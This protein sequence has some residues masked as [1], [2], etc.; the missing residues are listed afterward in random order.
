MSATFTATVLRWLTGRLDTFADVIFGPSY[1]D[2]PFAGMASVM[3]VALALVFAVAAYSKITDPDQTAAEFEQLLVPAPA[4]T[5]RVIPLAEML[6]SSTLIL[7][8][9]VG[10]TLAATMLGAFT[11]LLVVTVRSGRTVS[12]G[13]L[14]A[15]ST[16]PISMA[17]VARNF[18]FLAM[19]IFALTV[20]ALTMPSLAS[21]LVLGSMVVLGAMVIQLIAL[22]HAVGRIWSVQLA[23]ETANAGSRTSRSM[24]GNR[25]G[26]T[27]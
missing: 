7:W 4:I 20:P 23:G 5:A 15:L 14:G 8:P 10:A 24:S 27:A 18:V 11:T 17:T 2:G 3:A 22:H 16:K 25:K 13:C 26:M 19:A 6:V 12:C 21:L 9:R 1:V